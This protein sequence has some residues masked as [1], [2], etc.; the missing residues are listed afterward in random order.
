[1]AGGCRDC[2][3]CTETGFTTI[4]KLPF[5]AVALIWRIPMGMFQKKCPQCGHQM[6]R[7]QTI[8]GRLAD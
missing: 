1:M 2:T 8:G 5:R 7:H 4:W 6:S 3:R